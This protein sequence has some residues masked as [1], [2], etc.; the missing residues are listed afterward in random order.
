MVD[1][2]EW[3]EIRDFAKINGFSISPLAERKLQEAKDNELP[4]RPETPKE[5]KQTN[6][7]KEI[8]SKDAEIPK[9]LMDDD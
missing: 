8:L 6:K 5:E 2:K 3:R 9:D 1:P 4:V 7:L